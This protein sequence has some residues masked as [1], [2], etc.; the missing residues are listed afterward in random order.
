MAVAPHKMV[1]MGEEDDSI[2]SRIGIGLVIVAVL[3]LIVWGISEVKLGKSGAPKRQ[4]VKITLPDMPPP[5][6]PRQEEKKPEPKEDDKAAPQMEQKPLDAP[7]QVAQSLKMEG[8]AGDGPS[9][10]QSGSVSKDYKDG[11]TT[12]GPAGGAGTNSDRAK[13][14]FYVNSTKQLLKDDLERHL[15]TDQKQVVV[16]FS[17]WVKPDGSVDHYELVPTGSDRADEDI[18]AAFALMSKSTRLPPPRDTPQPLRL[19]L[20]LLPIAS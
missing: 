12:T 18:K 3:A 10:F 1:T 6:P 11:L 20:T 9:A 14:Q 7:P 2:G 5:P 8:A 16:T 17:I 15:Q 13:Y 19:R 4:T